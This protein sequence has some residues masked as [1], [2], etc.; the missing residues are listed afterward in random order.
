MK[1]T[2]P[3]NFS[4]WNW[5]LTQIFGVGPKLTVNCGECNLTFSKRIQLISNPG[6]QCKYCGAINIIPITVE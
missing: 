6:V 4:G 1:T 2:T 5:S 3:T